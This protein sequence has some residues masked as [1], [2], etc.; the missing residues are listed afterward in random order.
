M[1]GEDLFRVSEEGDLKELDRLILEG[2]DVNHMIN[3]F[4]IY[5]S[6]MHYSS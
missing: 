4:D 3:V 6:N 5:H 2:A 1:F